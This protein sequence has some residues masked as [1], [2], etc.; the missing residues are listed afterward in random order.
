MKSSC[1]RTVDWWDATQ[2][3]AMMCQSTH[4]ICSTLVEINFKKDGNTHAAI[5]EVKCGRKSEEATE[6]QGKRTATTLCNDLESVT[7]VIEG[8]SSESI[9]DEIAPTAKCIKDT[10]KRNL[11]TRTGLQKLKRCVCHLHHKQ[12][13]NAPAIVTQV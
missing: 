3:K 11:V 13:T 7:M 9:G 1:L 5:F 8:T 2:A 10:K 6:Y 4:R 12:A